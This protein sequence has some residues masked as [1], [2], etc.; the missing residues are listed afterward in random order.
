[1]TN[2]KAS[3]VSDE[4]LAVAD[5]L[6]VALYR[7]FRQIKRESAEI[8]S[9]IS[10][11]QNLLLSLINERP[12]IGVGELASLEKL[13]GPT[14]SGHIKN[15]LAAGMVARAAPDKEDRRRVGLLLTDKG[16]ETL[17]ALRER[18]RDWLARQLDG[19][20]PDSLA[21]IRKAIG[22]LSELGK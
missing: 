2:P 9:G 4:A 19:L 6:R 18:R 17:E 10:P 3:P 7:L 22:P 12:G 15:L 21:A 11:L 8:N 20:S 16:R 13:R 14:V 5:G 1:M